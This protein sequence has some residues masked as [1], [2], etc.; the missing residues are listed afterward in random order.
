MSR[1]PDPKESL[2]EAGRMIYDK[3]AGPRG[4][5]S[6]MYLSLMNHPDLAE[7]VGV[8]GTYLRFEGVLPGDVRETAI[9]A[10]ARLMNSGYEWEKHVGPARKEDVSDDTI[11]ALRQGDFESEKLSARDRKF[12]HVAKLVISNAVIPKPLQDDLEAELGLKGVVELVTLVG[13][14]RMINAIIVSFDV[15]LPEEGPPPF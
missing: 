9:L 14:Y 1:L 8:L 15:E 11:E 3:L 4:G 2:D 7:H 12:C 6:G 5:L 10:A 13:F